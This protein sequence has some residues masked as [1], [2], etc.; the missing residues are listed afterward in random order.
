MR[1]LTEKLTNSTSKYR[2]D[3]VTEDETYRCTHL[4]GFLVLSCAD[5]KFLKSWSPKALNL[6]QNGNFSV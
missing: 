6:V 4:K 2:K 3:I 1:G 5:I